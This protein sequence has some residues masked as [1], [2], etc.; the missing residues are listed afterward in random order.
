M[1]GLGEEDR[2][3]WRYVFIY[4]NTTIDLYPDQV[5]T[6]QLLPDGVGS[7]HDIVRR[8]TAPPAAAHARASCSG[9]I[10]G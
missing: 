10:S 9:P 3:T 7:T 8:A 4:P 1:P 5:N 6:W 2:H